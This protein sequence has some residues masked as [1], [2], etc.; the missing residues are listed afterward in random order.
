MR[1][2]SR[3][4]FTLVELLVVIAIIGILIALLL[5]AVQAAREAARRMQC[6]N[7]LKQIGLGCHNY[8]STYNVFPAGGRGTGDWSGN[9]WSYAFGISWYVAILPHLEEAAVYDQTNMS[10]TIHLQHDDTG[11]KIYAGFV[12]P[13]L[14]CPSSTMPKETPEPAGAVANPNYVGIAGAVAPKLD[15]ARRWDQDNVNVHAYNGMLFGG[16][17]VAVRDVSDGTSNVFMVGEQSGWVYDEAA[18]GR[19]TDCRSCGPHG[20]WIGAKR[21]DPVGADIGSHMYDKRVFNTTT[22]GPPIN[23][24]VCNFVRDYTSNAYY[25]DIVTNM[26]NQAP[27]T[28]AH[29]AGVNFLFADGSVHCVDVNIDYTLYQTFAIRDSGMVKDEGGAW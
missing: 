12:P 26:D 8:H 10:G 16:G 5:P 14:S 21:L 18:N 9:G 20:A 24:N 25:G 27:V 2:S 29:P 15:S 7:N 22:I 23:A 19:K 28:S 3:T 1:P 11:N 13:F 17:A 4:G 6:S